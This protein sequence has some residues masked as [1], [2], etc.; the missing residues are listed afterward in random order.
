MPG[1]WRRESSR[2]QEWIMRS[3]DWTSQ[4]PEKRSKRAKKKVG[5]PSTPQFQPCRGLPLSR[6]SLRN[7]STSRTIS[8]PLGISGNTKAD[9]S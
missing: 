5:R 7:S 4:M 1:A 2:A 9:S 8:S 3:F 6:W